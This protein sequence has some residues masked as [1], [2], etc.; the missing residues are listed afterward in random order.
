MSLH[1]V[2]DHARVRILSKFMPR[3][4]RLLVLSVSLTLALAAV[5][6]TTTRN[7]ASTSSKV[8]GTRAGFSPGGAMVWESDA[9]LARD[10][11]AARLTGA[12]WVRVE[13]NWNAIQSGG[14]NWW[15]WD[16]LDRMVSALHARGMRMIGTLAYAP[17]WARRSSCSGTMTCPPANAG[18]FANF[19]RVAAARYAPLGV[20]AWEVWNEPNLPAWWASGTNAADY[21]ALLKPT[22]VAIKGADRYATVVSGGMG[23]HGDLGA[24]PNDPQSPINYVKAMYAAGARGYFDALGHHPYPPLPHEPLSGKI[25]WNALLQTTWLHSIMSSN[26]DGNKQIWGTEYGAPTGPAGYS[27]TVSPNAQA[28]YIVTGFRYWTSLPYTG[29]L[30]VDNIRD[31]P[32]RRSDDWHSNMGLLYQNFGSKPA[33][34]AMSSIIQH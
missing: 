14:P 2:V 4:A 6:C 22:Y 31:A 7:A 9:D 25:G 18:A 15:R 8:P 24:T 33:L 5:G 19:A 20:H 23:P 21:V 34:G 32:T 17:A 3:R 10:L 28:Q 27:F 1:E 11:N 30:F 26:G 13:V 16:Y 12:K 29:P